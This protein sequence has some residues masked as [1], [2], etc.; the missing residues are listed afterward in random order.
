MP[1]AFNEQRFRMTN[2]DALSDWANSIGEDTDRDVNPTTPV[3]PAATPTITHPLPPA[4]SNGNL[5]YKEKSIQ[6]GLSAPIP[7]WITNLPKDHDWSQEPDPWAKA[8]A[9]G[10]WDP[11]RMEENPWEESPRKC[12]EWK[13]GEQSWHSE[14]T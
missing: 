11:E 7:A 1:S 3:N 13:A 12:D 5:M 4:D 2:D 6:R 9:T 8:K 10:N 14:D